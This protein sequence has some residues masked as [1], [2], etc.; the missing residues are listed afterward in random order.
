MTKIYVLIYPEVYRKQAEFHEFTI[1]PSLIESNNLSEWAS[2]MSSIVDELAKD[3]E[4][5]PSWLVGRLPEVR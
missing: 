5:F 3:E 4:K 1:P 2:W